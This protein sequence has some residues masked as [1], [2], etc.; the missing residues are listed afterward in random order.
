MTVE[1]LNPEP[2]GSSYTSEKRARY[3]VRRGIAEFDPFGRLQFL[4]RSDSFKTPDRVVTGG[5]EIRIV[6][7]WRFPHVQFV[8]RSQEA[9]T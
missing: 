9:I 2:G 1:I 6:D 4:N 8:H 7:S 3:F 5:F